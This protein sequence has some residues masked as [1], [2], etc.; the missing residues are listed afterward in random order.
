MHSCARVAL[1]SAQES[2]D[3]AAY[4]LGRAGTAIEYRTN[5]D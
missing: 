1:R 5:N 4:Q 2:L 3:S